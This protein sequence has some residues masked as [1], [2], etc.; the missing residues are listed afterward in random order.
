MRF[1]SV[2]FLS[3][4]LASTGCATSETADAEKPITKE[5]RKITV[6][7]NNFTAQSLTATEKYVIGV[8]AIYSEVC[9]QFQGSGVDQNVLVTLKRVFGGDLYFQKGYAAYNGFEGWDKVIGVTECGAT[10]ESLTTIY[11]RLSS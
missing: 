11:R 7:S 4:F 5:L 1:L 10:K 6:K 9:A 3:F 8:G 2:V